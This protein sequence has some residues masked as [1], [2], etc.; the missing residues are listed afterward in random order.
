MTA[1]AGGCE[2]M[3]IDKRNDEAKERRTEDMKHDRKKSNHIMGT[4]IQIQLLITP[5]DNY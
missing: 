5:Q 1:R 2:R 4:R 3:W